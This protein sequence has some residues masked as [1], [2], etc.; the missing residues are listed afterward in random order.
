MDCWRATTIHS[1]QYN[2]KLYI[3]MIAFIFIRQGKLPLIFHSEN[4]PFSLKVSKNSFFA[5]RI[6][7]CVFIRIEHLNF[8]WM[9]QVCN[10]HRFSVYCGFY[11]KGKPS[12]MVKIMSCIDAWILLAL[13]VTYYDTY[14]CRQEHWSYF[15]LFLNLPCFVLP[16]FY[17]NR[18]Q[19]IVLEMFLNDR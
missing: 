5:F 8:G 18:S 6:Q 11:K 16:T 7:F 4:L 14:H 2:P 9:W 10:F 13:L 17:T 12:K 19:D 1:S 15:S 3:N